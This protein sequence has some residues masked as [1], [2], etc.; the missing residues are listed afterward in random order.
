MKSLND[1]RS[2]NIDLYV[3]VQTEPINL[4][5]A[6]TLTDQ[7]H[8]PKCRTVDFID[9]NIWM[10]SNNHAP[11]TRLMDK[12]DLNFQ[13]KKHFFC[14]LKKEC[15]PVGCEPHAAVA[16]CCGGGCLPKCMLGYTPWAWW[17]PRVWAWRPPSCLP[18]PPTSPPGVGLDTPTSPPL[19]TEFL[20]HASENITLPQLLCGR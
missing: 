2:A 11:S 4:A 12:N 17:S 9:K 16:V 19:W 14:N 10:H 7:K 6:T 5:W 13:K 3:P 18:D 8:F 1:T 20:T 15:I